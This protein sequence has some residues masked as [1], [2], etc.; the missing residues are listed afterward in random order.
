MAAENA[1]VIDA[2]EKIDQHIE[3]TRSEIMEELQEQALLYAYYEG[4][5]NGLKAAWAIV[6]Q[7]VYGKETD[8]D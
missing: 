3:F 5:M 8:T 6:Y 4:Y 7:A 1:N 2:L